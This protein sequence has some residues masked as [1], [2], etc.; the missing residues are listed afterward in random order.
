MARETILL[1]HGAGLGGWMW[2][3]VA[4]LLRPRF[5]VLTPDLPGHP[6]SELPHFTTNADAADA[7]AA[8]LDNPVTAVGFS[9]GGQVAMELA[10]RHPHLVERLAV[11]S[12]LSSRS[13]SPTAMSVV[14]RV[15]APLARNRRFARA[16]AKASFVPE[17]Q[18]EH[19]WRS[20]RHV[21]AQSLAAIG[22]ENFAYR[23][24][25]GWGERSIPTLLLAGGREPRAVAQG[26][27]LLQTARPDA[28]FELV[29]DAGHSVP[30]DRPAWLAARLERFMLEH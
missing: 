7:I 11:V 5:D 12:S 27:R 20:S 30:L 15:T 19:Y 8:G 17:E 22:R 2:Q 9:I 10:S 26:M 24:P 18:F 3:P 21:S 13:F 14:M 28:E 4:D 1:L 23:A 25:A 6:E 29:A 16:Q